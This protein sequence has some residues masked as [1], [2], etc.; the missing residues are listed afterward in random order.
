MIEKITTMSQRAFSF[1]GIVILTFHTIQDSIRNTNATVN[2]VFQEG[3]FT[4]R[5]ESSLNVFFYSETRYPVFHCYDGIFKS[6]CLRKH[7]DSYVYI[8]LRC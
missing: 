7:D 3:F 4:A 5:D 8:K 2:G 1:S 6:P